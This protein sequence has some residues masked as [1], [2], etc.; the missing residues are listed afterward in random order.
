MSNSA[1]QLR[2]ATEADVEFLARVLL[3]T[4]QDRYSQHPGWDPAE[5]YQGVVDDAADQVAGN[6]PDSTTFVITQEGTDIGRLRLVTTSIKIEVAG[7][8][9]LPAHQ[10]QGIGTAVINSVLDRAHRTGIPVELEVENDN[11]DARRLYER[12]G[13]RADGATRWNRVTL[14][15]RGEPFAPLI[16]D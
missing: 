1:P 8:Q 9:I 5:F 10:N 12:L 7:L 13:F 6:V 3:V 11:P 15:H 2:I 16:T 4:N 14:V